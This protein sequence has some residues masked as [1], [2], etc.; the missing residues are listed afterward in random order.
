MAGDMDSTTGTSDWGRLGDGGGLELDLYRRE[1]LDRVFQ[2][3]VLLGLVALGFGAWL[4][5]RDGQWGFAI[6]Y[7]ALYLA[8]T[9]FAVGSKRLSVETR[10]LALL[11][12]LYAVATAALLRLGINGT[13]FL[14]LV[15]CC[16][17]TAILRGARASLWAV[18]FCLLAVAIAAG[19]ILLGHIELTPTRLHAS[20]SL[21]SWIAA[22]ITFVAVTIGLI[23]PVHVLSGK[24]AKL[25]GSLERKTDELKLSNARLQEEIERR[26]RA[27]TAL[28]ASELRYRG[29]FEGTPVGIWEEDLS[30][31]RAALASLREEGVEDVRGYLESH[32]EFVERMAALVRIQDVNQST[33]STF[34]ANSKEELLAALHPTSVLASGERFRDLLIALAEGSRQFEGE[35]SSHNL[36]G[37]RIQL[38]VRAA[39]PEDP[40]ANVLVSTLDIT[41]RKE[42]EK[43]LAQAQKM[44]AVGTLAGGLAHDFNNLLMGIRGTAALLMRRTVGQEKVREHLESIDHLVDSGA[45]LTGQLLGFARGGKYE[46]QITD[47]SELLDCSL[48]IFARTKKEIRTEKNLSAELWTV[49]VDRNQ[50]EQVLLNLF[51]NAWHAMPGGGLLTVDAENVN[52][53]AQGAKNL[54]IPS[55]EYVR[56]AVR[57]TGE[58]MNAQTCARV[59]EPFFTTRHLGHGTGLGLASA[60]GIV[61]NHGGGLSVESVP[62]EGTTFFVHLPASKK[63]MRRAEE[64]CT[65]VAEGEEMILLID[66]EELVLRATQLLLEEVGYQVVTAGDGAEA[67]RL[68]EE[69]RDEISLVVL[70]M[71]M[72]DMGGADVFEKLRAMAEDVPV[73]LSSGYAR[74]VKADDLLRRG[75][76]GFIQKPF[77]LEE[78]S[79]RVREII[80]PRRA[81]GRDGA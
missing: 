58:G 26:E 71:I 70:D 13:G 33:V 51:L 47:V 59:F 16:G 75:A 48:S 12:G 32:P 23:V 20:L 63:P 68:F 76:K 49:D 64:P 72:P 56:I 81:N 30:E 31:V 80:K 74:D 50:I 27:E 21:G 78:M 36:R 6:V 38:L 28:R 15:V 18:G 44:E 57:D 34:G 54:G 42:L 22:G 19:A 79:R 37:D 61:G 65:G 73:L 62:G 77:G 10:S 1:L 35:T 4:A 2:P 67:L 14:L 8:S 52:L 55:G 66:D 3:F 40:K 45:S 7:L 29:I 53:D 41:D 39:I 5:V 9:V 60:Y 69:H 24:L 11:V 46:S 17:L 43:S 25:L